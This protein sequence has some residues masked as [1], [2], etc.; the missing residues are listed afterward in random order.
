MWLSK[1]LVRPHF[2]LR[3]RTTACVPPNFQSVGLIIQARKAD[4]ATQETQ[5]SVIHDASS[6]LAKKQDRDVQGLAA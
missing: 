5:F 4:R 1:L 6:L 2:H 3:R